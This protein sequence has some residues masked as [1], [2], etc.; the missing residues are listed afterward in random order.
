[1]GNGDLWWHVGHRPVLS[2]PRRGDPRYRRPCD[3][4]GVTTHQLVDA[5]REIDN[6]PHS[7][8]GQRDSDLFSAGTE[9]PLAGR[10]AIE[11]APEALFPFGVNAIRS[12]A[13]YDSMVR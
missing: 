8:T 2:N 6:R 9:R 10:H 11:V 4:N 1:M 12:R 7:Q 3:K 13:T 5:R